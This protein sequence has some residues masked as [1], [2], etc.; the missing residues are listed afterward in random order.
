ML[1][2]DPAE[3]PPLEPRQVPTLS[4][5]GEPL[6]YH[7]SRG[8][9]AA[10]HPGRRHHFRLRVPPGGEYRSGVVPFRRARQRVHFLRECSGILETRRRVA[11]SEAEALRG[12]EIRRSY[13]HLHRHNHLVRLTL[14]RGHAVGLHHGV[15]RRLL[16]HL[17]GGVASVLGQRGGEQGGVVPADAALLAAARAAHLHKG[18][19]VYASRHA[20]AGVVPLPCVGDCRLL[21]I[22]RGG[23]PVLDARK[24]FASSET[25][26]FP[27]PALRRGN[28]HLHWLDRLVRLTLRRGRAVGVHYDLLRRLPIHRGG[29]GEGVGRR[30]RSPQRTR[31]RAGPVLHAVCRGG[32]ADAASAARLEY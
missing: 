2:A 23:A 22:L 26:A 25:E 18:L 24:R 16:S 9:G 27:G 29:D 10:G 20:W 17:L 21:H 30:R 14:Q 12:P 3:P 32:G 4:G 15:L 8:R 7:G 31:L 1:H 28:T 11:T 13:T 6:L 19:C 5:G